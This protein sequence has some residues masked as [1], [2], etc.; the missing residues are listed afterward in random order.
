VSGRF[1]IA[2]TWRGERIIPTK[3]D[4]FEYRARRFDRCQRFRSR[5]TFAD[6]ERQYHREHGRYFWWRNAVE[7]AR[8]I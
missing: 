5:L 6:Q 8:G 2:T 1:Y 7:M 3:R 4:I